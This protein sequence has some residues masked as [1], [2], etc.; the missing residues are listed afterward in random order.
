MGALISSMRKEVGDRASIEFAV[1]FYDAL[2]AGMSFEEAF[3]SGCGAILAEFPYETQHLIPVLKKRG[4][5][6]NR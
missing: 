4:G 2:G 3:E 1:G 5:K 6:L